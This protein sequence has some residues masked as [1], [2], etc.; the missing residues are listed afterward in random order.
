MNTALLELKRRAQDTRVFTTTRATWSLTLK[1]RVNAILDALIELP[2]TDPQ[3]APAKD[4]TM[5]DHE[6]GEELPPNDEPRAFTKKEN[7]PT[8]F[9]VKTNSEWGR[10]SACKRCGK[11]D[12]PADTYVVR[13]FGTGWWHDACY[14][15]VNP[16]YYVGLE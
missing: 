3:P 13:I 10:Y 9:R 2:I 15:V 8:R 16:E 6:T 1:N 14:R 5:W 4:R 7:T 12:A 11:N